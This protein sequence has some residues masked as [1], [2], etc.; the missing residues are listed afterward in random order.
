MR[1]Q[2]LTIED[3]SRWPDAHRL[4]PVLTVEN[5]TDRRS[6]IEPR[7]GRSSCKTKIYAP[8]DNAG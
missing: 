3:W 1:R 7:G 8:Q 6:G 2:E 4:S 5:A